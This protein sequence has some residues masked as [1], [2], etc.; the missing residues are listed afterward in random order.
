MALTAQ[1]IMYRARQRVDAVESLFFHDTSELLVWCDQSHRELYDLLVASYGQPYFART[2]D[3]TVTTTGVYDLTLLPTAGK[4]AFYKLLRADVAFN[5]VRVP[6]HPLALSDA[7][8]YDTP[9]SWDAGRDIHY[10]LADAAIHFV[11]RPSASQ[12][13]RLYY[14]PLPVALTTM[15]TPVH[16][17]CEH[18]SEYTVVDLAIKMR[19]KEESDV[20]ALLQEKLML[21]Q[22]ITQMAQDRDAGQPLSLVDVRTANETSGRHLHSEWW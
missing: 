8:L 14:V 20:A 21:G 9:Q 12:T 1:E 16:P 5:S 3:V 15:V 19:T 13:V 18:W 4:P 7:V 17:A 2:E 11:P 6:L 10:R 22:R